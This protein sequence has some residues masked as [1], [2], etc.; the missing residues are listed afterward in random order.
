VGCRE[1][2]FA[3][4][5]Q[6]VRAVIA[7]RTDRELTGRQRIRDTCSAAHVEVRGRG[8]MQAIRAACGP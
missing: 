7:G 5:D 1:I 8:K 2:Q 3:G 4:Q 6:H